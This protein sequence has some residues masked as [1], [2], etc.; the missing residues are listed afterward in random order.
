MKKFISLAIAVLMIFSMSLSVFALVCEDHSFTL[1]ASPDVTSV[2]AGASL[3]IAIDMGSTDSKLEPTD[4][5]GV[6]VS[7]NLVFDAT[8]FTY[9]KNA[10][11]KMDGVTLTQRID[12]VNLEATFTEEVDLET[13]LATINLTV[14]DGA[15]SKDY[16]FKLDDIMVYDMDSEAEAT[17]TPTNATV[18]V[19]AGGSTGSTD[20]VVDSE[21]FTG[22]DYNELHTKDETPA[23]GT[24]VKIS[25][26]DEEGFATMGAN[27]SIKTYFKKNGTGDVL[28]AGTYGITVTIGETKYKFPGKADV[29]AGKAWAIKLVIPEGK[30]ANNETVGAFG[31]AEEY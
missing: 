7:V 22:A 20:I 4:S 11:T 24:V 30:F 15:L 26:E 6:S 21:E 9:N 19:T 13:S 3:N 2:S 25:G 5:F 18:T 16:I 1:T 28:K 12:G 17:I 14:V 8:V 23:E 31:V 10:S 27:G 29:P